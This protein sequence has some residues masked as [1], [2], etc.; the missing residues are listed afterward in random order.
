MENIT[1]D[2]DVAITSLAVSK[3]TTL[4]IND[5]KIVMQI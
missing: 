1:E 3:A 2:S 5:M 4:E